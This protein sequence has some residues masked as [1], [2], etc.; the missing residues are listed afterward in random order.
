MFF[1]PF[2]SHKKT[3]ELVQRHLAEFDQAAE[4]NKEMEA[5]VPTSGLIS[6]LNPLEVLEIFER[7]PAEDVPLLL[8]DAESARPAHM[9]LT[10]L[11]VPPLCIRPSVVSD[12]KSGTNEASHFHG[13]T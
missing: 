9:I 5:L 13:K 7:I 1:Q 2:R 11:A 8:M 4:S 10:R 12:L 6:V 3:S